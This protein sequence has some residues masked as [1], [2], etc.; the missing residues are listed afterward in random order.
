M[1]A[2][3]KNK[4]GRMSKLF[5]TSKCT[6]KFRKARI[7]PK[8]KR[9]FNEDREIGFDFDRDIEARLEGMVFREQFAVG[10]RNLGI[11]NLDQVQVVE[12][13]DW[14]DAGKAEL[15]NTLAVDRTRGYQNRWGKD[16]SYKENWG[17]PMA[18]GRKQA[19]RQSQVSRA[20]VVEEQPVTRQQ[21]ARSQQPAASVRPSSVSRKRAYAYNEYGLSLMEDGDYRGAT[22]NFKEAIKLDPIEDVYKI[23]LQRCSE[24]LNYKKKRRR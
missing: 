14:P 12:K 19:R 23:N 15:G 3:V 22:N 20:V 16:R 11:G 24:W 2:V 6:A 5:D 9:S 17:T 13:D 8:R 1:S 7:R 18:P 4:K 10:F 21:P